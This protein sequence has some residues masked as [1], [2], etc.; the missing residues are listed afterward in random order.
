MTGT[1]LVDLTLPVTHGMVGHPR[2]PYSLNPTAVEFVAAA[3][4]AD[5]D[6]LRQRG[7]EVADDARTGYLF[8]VTRQS[9]LVHVFTHIDTP[10]HFNI[11]GW[12]TDNLDL[13]RTCGEAVVLDFTQKQPGEEI[14]A[15][16]L[17]AA[18][19]G[20]VD[21]SVIPIIRTGWTD[22]AWG[23][24]EFYTRA[25]CFAP[26][27]ADWF[28]DRRVRA[29]AVDCLP[30]VNMNDPRRAADP[31]RYLHHRL[32]GQGVVFI[33]NLVN[34]GALRSRRVTLLALPM[35]VKGA[36]AALAR[37]LAWDPALPQC[38][39]PLPDLMNPG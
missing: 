4:A 22:R 13:S 18:A 38:V 27:A 8:P 34:L 14:S 9:C 32:L 39:L 33:S 35:K 29:I 24:P 23:S 30:D 36:E 6:T 17:E 37:V 28:L 16:D 7:F 26:D 20:D 5:L 3:S 31:S 15:A 25:I 1:R 2:P 10:V 21:P 11:H 12:S 19:G